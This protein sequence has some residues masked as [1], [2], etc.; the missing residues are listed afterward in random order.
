ML[1]SRILVVDTFASN[2]TGMDKEKMDRNVQ[3]LINKIGEGYTIIHSSV[4]SDHGFNATAY[5]LCKE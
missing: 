2:S 5:I 1:V 4:Y 3:D